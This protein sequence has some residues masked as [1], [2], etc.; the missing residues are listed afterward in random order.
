MLT[1]QDDATIKFY[2]A[3]GRSSRIG[4]HFLV[5]VLA[6]VFSASQFAADRVEAASQPPRRDS[7]SKSPKPSTKSRIPA[8]PAPRPTPPPLPQIRADILQGEVPA[9]GKFIVRTNP[10][11]AEGNCVRFMSAPSY[12]PAVSKLIECLT[13]G[14]VSIT[15]FDQKANNGGITWRVVRT[16]TSFAWV[17]ST[18]LEPQAPEEATPVV[19]AVVDV[20]ATSSWAPTGSWRDLITFLSQLCTMANAFKAVVISSAIVAGKRFW[21]RHKELKLAKDLR[22]MIDRSDIRDATHFYV[23]TRIQANCPTEGAEPDPHAPNR[24]KAIP[25]FQAIIRRVFRGES[26]RRV[27]LV[28]AD[29]GMGKTTFLINFLIKSARPFRRKGITLS[30]FALG[31]PKAAERIE[32]LTPAERKDTVLLLDAFDEDPLAFA[33]YKQRLEDLISSVTEFPV[34]IITCRTQF[35]PSAADIP[36]STG[37]K[38]YA[39]NPHETVFEPFFVAPFNRRDIRKYLRKRF[40]FPHLLRRH[41]ARMVVRRTRHLMARPM[42]L[43]HVGI[44]VNSKRTYTTAF[45]IYGVMVEHWAKRE[46]KKVNDPN[47]GMRLRAFSSA[48]AVNL[49]VNRKSR[50]GLQVSPAEIQDLADSKRIDLQALTQHDISSRSLLVRTADGQLKFAHKSILEYFLSCAAFGNVERLKELEDGEYELVDQTKIFLRERLR[51]ADPEGS[52]SDMPPKDLLDNIYYRDAP[53]PNF[54]S[55]ED[56]TGLAILCG[57]STDPALIRVTSLLSAPVGVYL[58]F[59]PDVGIRDRLAEGWAEELCSHAKVTLQVRGAHLPASAGLIQQFEFAFEAKN[60]RN[61]LSK[62]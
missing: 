12:E 4:A 36:T 7:K 25:W 27:F 45:E 49:W 14:S 29:S 59:R 33:N 24:D 35:F 53:M 57:T 39:P 47:L 41:R 8:P 38:S 6:L 60:I 15:A 51:V 1:P 58:C 56:K 30:M 5:S 28:L 44:L 43:A 32:K 19:A 52:F 21:R 9:A 48:L 42:L 26:S 13:D 22:P 50:R 55:A 16:K 40:R 34:V 20:A 2:P 54:M 10:A 3:P 61:R 37:L 11:S 46:A 18:S 62:A 17:D 23:P 31:D